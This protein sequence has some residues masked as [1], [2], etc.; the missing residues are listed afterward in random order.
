M[1]DFP[2]QTVILPE[3]RS[4]NV[5]VGLI[6]LSPGWVASGGTS[7]KLPARG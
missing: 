4:S 7:G 2:W 5:A 1:V 6:A 3:R